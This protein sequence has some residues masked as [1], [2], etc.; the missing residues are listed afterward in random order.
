MRSAG[1][2]TLALAAAPIPALGQFFSREAIGFSAFQGDQTEPIPGFLLA[3]LSVA[4]A[5]L[6]SFAAFR[7]YYLVL[8]GERRP[9]ESKVTPKSKARRS[10]TSEAAPADEKPEP[11]TGWPRLLTLACATLAL[12]TGLLGA[13][14]KPFDP[15]GSF[16]APFERWLETPAVE[17]EQPV[18]PG[19]GLRIGL[20]VIG[21]LLPLGAWRVASKW[22]G[23]ASAENF[24]DRERQLPGRAWLTREPITL[25]ATGMLGRDV[26]RIGSVLQR[27]DRWLAGGVGG[28]PVVTADADQASKA[29]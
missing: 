8:S 13:S 2:A 5:T 14:S 18:G 6:I 15:A 20:L 10:R 27:T 22:Y 12:T 16:R 23:R 25:R 28:E 26:D 3:A 7:V 11:P 19:P 4:A 17:N 21:F 9:A 29:P 1:A 24:E